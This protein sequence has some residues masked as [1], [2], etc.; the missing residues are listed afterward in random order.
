MKE[1][2]GRSPLQQETR[3]R[4]L[5]PRKPKIGQQETIR[6]SPSL[7]RKTEIGQRGRPPTLPPT[8]LERKKALPSTETKRVPT[9]PWPSASLS[10]GP[11]TRNTKKQLSPTKTKS[12]RRSL[13]RPTPPSKVISTKSKSNPKNIISSSL[14]TSNLMK[15]N[16]SG[17]SRT[18]LKSKN[19][20]NVKATNGSIKNQ[21]SRKTKD[22]GIPVKAIKKKPNISNALLSPLND[23]NIVTHEEHNH[24]VVT[25]ENN[26]ILHGK[27][28]CEDG[29]EIC[30]SEPS[31]SVSLVGDQVVPESEICCD[32]NVSFDGSIDNK[33]TYDHDGHINEQDHSNETFDIISDHLDHHIVDQ[34]NQEPENEQVV[35]EADFGSTD[36]NGEA[37]DEDI[38][39]TKLEE[40]EDP[41]HEEI[42]PEEPESEETKL[43]E[44][45]DEETERD[46][47]VHEENKLEEL[48]H[49]EMK[50]D[51]HEETD[52]EE[53]EP[54][55][56]EDGVEAP[57]A[58]DTTSE[59]AIKSQEVVMHGKKDSATYNDVIEETVSKLREQSK[60]RVLALAG[61][62]ETVISLEADL[63]PKEL[64]PKSC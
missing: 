43:E 14:K 31:D 54:D 39:E 17:T 11:S 24:S 7:P 2:R 13:D 29:G 8:L 36:E 16:V 56:P 42:K 33:H 64:S 6:R 9:I 44:S 53:A 18:P 61:A 55:E 58:E 26:D 3:D 34:E 46:E 59:V 12:L 49:E 63:S 1:K 28:K 60:N 10:R 50:P 37:E 20:L 21:T 15:P 47:L 30:V 22:L 32:D 48:E 41:E 51:E 45:E 5:L 4:S 27:V 52:I 23:H 25:Q 57:A 40:P 38:E 35:E 62:F 19:S